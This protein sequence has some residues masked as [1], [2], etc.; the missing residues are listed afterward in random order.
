MKYIKYIQSILLFVT[1]IIVGSCKKD[2]LEIDDNTA[3]YRQSYVKDLA[4]MKDFLNGVYFK[5][6]V[7]FE[8]ATSQAYPE[9]IA[10]NLKPLS[11]TGSGYLSSHYTWSQIPEL[12]DGSDYPG[13]SRSATAMNSLWRM[14]YQIAHACSFVISE[15][16]KYRKENEEV[17]DDIKG[18]AYAIRALVHFKLVN[19]FA[20]PMD[21]S[22]GGNHIGIPYVNDYDISAPVIRLSVSEDYGN[23]IEDYKQAIKLLPTDVKDVR[24]MNIVAAQ[25]L[26]ARTYLFIGDYMNA[27]DLAVSITSKHP[28]MTLAQGY[29]DNI[30][31]FK[32]PLE[33]ETLYQLTPLGGGVVP[34]GFLGFALN[35]HPRGF[36]ATKDIVNILTENLDDV[37][38]KWVSKDQDE[39]QVV[40]FPTN[41]APEVDPAVTNPKIAYYSSVIRSSEM[42]LTVA[43]TSAKLG[44][45]NTSRTYLNA[46]R[47]RANP[48][49][50]LLTA[51]GTAL[52]DSIYK[53]RRKE[54]AFEGLRMF[55]LQR[56]G[57]GVQRIDAIFSYAKDLPYPNN[58]AIAP[59][60]KTDVQL[61]GLLQNDGY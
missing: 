4:T 47:K 36:L 35:G 28:L 34:S 55:D 1:L 3:L 8:Y 48:N 20:Q 61:L 15:T 17:A 24:I 26:L 7:N 14:G 16:D 19:V 59:I 38:T 33:T 52:L 43:E 60:P 29:P 40:K 50:V 31:Q 39:W 21:F 54:L 45:E 5:Y 42:F 6:A 37:R 41:V 13:N 46:I 22:K 51:T 2:F 27:R 32:K 11:R 12:G 53:E 57:K 10:D 23:I 49:I 58:K 25:A 9:V 56:T 44:D 30:F 18:Q